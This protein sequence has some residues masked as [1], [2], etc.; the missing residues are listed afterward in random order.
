MVTPH[1]RQP[2][3][4]ISW[5]DF[6]RIVPIHPLFQWFGGLSRAGMSLAWLGTAHHISVGIGGATLITCTIL[7]YRQLIES[8]PASRL[9]TISSFLFSLEILLGQLILKGEGRSFLVGIHFAISVI[10]LGS[11]SATAMLVYNNGNTK[12]NKR[13]NFSKKSTRQSVILVCIV[14]IILISGAW[15]A[16][17]GNGNACVGWPLCNGS[18]IPDKASIAPY[19]HRLLVLIVGVYLLRFVNDAWK[20]HR[21][22]KTILPLANSLLILFIAQGYMGALISLREFPVGLVV[23]HEITAALIIINGSLLLISLGL[24]SGPEKKEFGAVNPGVYRKQRFNDFLQLNK[25]VV[26]SLLLA[27]T[28]AGMIMGYKGFPPIEIVLVT[29]VS[30]ALAAGGSGASTN[31]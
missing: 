27:T 30:G 19:M 22:E 29:L 26:V 8:H 15:L 1:L 16:G 6:W 31:P 5:Y 13:L 24:H 12:E 25:P 14:M 11:V 9:M 3:L 18:F 17:S 23:L 4:F 21:T 20:E 7:A 28:L 2:S 10:I